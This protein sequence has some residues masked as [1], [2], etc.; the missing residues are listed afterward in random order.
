[1]GVLFERSKT[2]GELFFFYEFNKQVKSGFQ[3]LQRCVTNSMQ[4]I[5]E[6][7]LFLFIFFPFIPFLS[8]FI[9]CFT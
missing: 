4:V 9:V 6:A 2:K 5:I 7:K 3:F 1:M 8:V